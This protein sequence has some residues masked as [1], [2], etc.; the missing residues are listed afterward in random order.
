MCSAEGCPTF[1]DKID[2]LKDKVK[3][4][5]KEKVKENYKNNK[6]AGCKDFST[7]VGEDSDLNVACS[8]N[9]GKLIFCLNFDK[10]FYLVGEST[11]EVGCPAG[12]SA[13]FGIEA[14]QKFFN[15]IANKT[16]KTSFNVVCKCKGLRCRWNSVR[17]PIRPVRFIALRKLECE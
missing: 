12:Q 2:I 3:N 14:V 16:E 1:S 7:I 17:G 15:Y 9:E 5:I 6:T 8:E 4:K 10:D 13:Q 11:C